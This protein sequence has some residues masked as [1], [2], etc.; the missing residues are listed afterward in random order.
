MFYQLKL[1]R[2]ET[3]YILVRHHPATVAKQSRADWLSMTFDTA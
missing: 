3:R 1:N 2:L